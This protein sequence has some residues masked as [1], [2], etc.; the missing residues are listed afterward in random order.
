MDDA[1][2]ANGDYAKFT[3]NG[4]QGREASEVRTDINVDVSGTVENNLTLYY[5][6]IL[7][8]GAAGALDAIDGAALTNGDGAIVITT[9]SVYFYWLDDDNA[10][11]ES[12]PDIISPDDN[13]G[14]KRWVLAKAQGAVYS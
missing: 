1:D 6:N 3:A 2:A 10:G 5:A 7:T 11:A 13:A 8:G 12:S 9:E 4:L 14:D